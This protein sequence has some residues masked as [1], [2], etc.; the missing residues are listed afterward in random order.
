MY[1][2]TKYKNVKSPDIDETLNI[3]DVFE[4]IKNGDSAL[5]HI[6]YARKFEK[7][8]E[9]Y[10]SIKTNLIP[11]FRFNFLFNEKALNKNIIKPTGLIFIDVDNIE[12]IAEN[13]FIFAKWKSIS[14]KGFSIL[15]KVD[16]LSLGNFNDCYEKISFLLKLNSDIGA[17]K[18]NQQTVQSFDPDIYINYDSK[19]FNCL[20]IKKVPSAIKQKKRKECLTRNET[21]LP[22]SQNIEV[23]FNNIDDY[24]ID[25][26]LPYLVFKDEKQKLC[27]PFIPRKVETGNRNNYLFI[28]LSQIVALNP[29]I[30]K[31]YIK[32]I[33]DSINLNVMEPKLLDNDLNKMINSIF[34]IKDFDELELFYN[35]E[36]RII[37]NPSHEITFGEKMKIVNK[38]LGSIKSIRT[39]EKIYE[40]IEEWDFKSNGKITQDK[41]A[42]L[43]NVHVSTIKRYWSNFK[44][45]VKELNDD[46]KG[47]IKGDE[48]EM[49]E[50]RIDYSSFYINEPQLKKSA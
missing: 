37:F 45:F 27:I 41:I 22:V 14:L 3:D 42:L 39:T 8:S 16:K 33:A 9:D 46:Y 25:N 43:I 7:G 19:T 2:V 23:R 48:T 10:D 21:F 6:L 31:T 5:S 15:V 28:Y 4:I 11:T 12:V 47:T 1:K 26:D 20:D 44:T 36:R 18:P 29:H 24:F 49:I 34:Q 30:N 13:D 32:A 17:R 38:E 35:K 50:C 40:C